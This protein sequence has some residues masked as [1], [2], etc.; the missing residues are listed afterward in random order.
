M[1]TAI[2]AASLV[3]T[4]SGATAHSIKSA[5]CN[6]QFAVGQPM[7]NILVQADGT[8]SGTGSRRNIPFTVKVKPDGTV[9]FF[10]PDGSLWY[11][12]VTMANGYLTATYH[13]PAANGGVV[14]RFT[15]ACI[16]R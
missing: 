13:Q 10:R 4:V 3:F 8:I 1:K 9:D 5:Y 12:S 16:M 6:G 14:G 2:F 7:L 11:E 15:V